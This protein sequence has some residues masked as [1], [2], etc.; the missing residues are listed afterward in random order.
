MWASVQEQVRELAC[1]AGLRDAHPAVVGVA[2]VALVAAIAW[3]GWH[4][5][6][7]SADASV[8]YSSGGS[9]NAVT[10]LTQST[11]PTEPPRA[12]RVTVHVV[13][14]VR[15]PGVYD[16]PDGARATDAIEAA[17]G[18]LPDAVP[19][20]VNLARE[21]AD[22][23][24]LVVPDE[25]DVATAPAALPQQT[26]SGSGGGVGGGSGPVD[27][28]TADAALLDTLPGIGPSTAAKIVTDRESNG[29]FASV[30]D[31][32]RVSGIGP[33]KIEQLEGLACVR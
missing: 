31:L 11:E 15:H 6:P 9:T 32:G 30:E 14:A 28:N 13:G 12:E 4:W 16:L 27:L 3:A 2:A 29:P 5:W 26:V 20:S 33:K 1:R 7:R 19:S 23:E 22:G 21:V 25:D 18:L 10:S 24:Q 8:A 17:G